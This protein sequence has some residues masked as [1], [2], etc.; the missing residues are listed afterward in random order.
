MTRT[1]PDINP[2]NRRRQESDAAGALLDTLEREHEALRCGDLN[3]LES[4]IQDKQRHVAQL[5]RLAREQNEGPARYLEENLK[6]I[7]TKCHKQNQ[8][9]ARLVEHGRRRISQALALLRGEPGDTVEYRP[10]D[11][12]QTKPGGR[13]IATI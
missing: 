8:I 10:R 3:A 9:N 4:L 1:T 5:T 7:L 12:D 6:N 11:R 13:L 2:I